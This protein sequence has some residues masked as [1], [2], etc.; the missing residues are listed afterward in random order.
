MNDARFHWGALIEEEA[1]NLNLKALNQ[2]ICML[3]S[4]TASKG[5]TRKDACRFIALQDESTQRRISNEIQ[6][7]LSNPTS[8]TCKMNWMLKRRHEDEEA[9]IRQVKSR[10]D[11]INNN[12]RRHGELILISIAVEIRI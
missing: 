12:L 9:E 5:R 6:N 1:K 3:P 7:L 2:L 8:D 4:Y 10:L 11:D